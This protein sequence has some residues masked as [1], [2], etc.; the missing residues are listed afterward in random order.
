MPIN[1]RTL[2]YGDLTFL[3]TICSYCVPIAA[4]DL[5]DEMETSECPIDT[6]YSDGDMVGFLNFYNNF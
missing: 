4:Y 3:T 1:R 2:S 5:P 6:Y